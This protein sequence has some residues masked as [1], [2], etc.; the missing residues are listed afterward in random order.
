M[1]QKTDVLS[2]AVVT[3]TT[4]ATGERKAPVK[5][6][7]LLLLRTPCCCCCQ[8][9]ARSSLFSPNNSCT[10][11]RRLVRH[12]DTNGATA[13]KANLHNNAALLSHTLCVVWVVGLWIQCVIR[14]FDKL[15]LNW[16]Y[17]FRHEP[18]EHWK[19]EVLADEWVPVFPAFNRPLVLWKKV[20]CLL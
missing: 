11:A 20:F 16:W 4:A 6:L 18:R 3:T 7:L 19:G 2:W 5:L 15:K 9:I 1:P 17:D 13:R 8:A 14:D 10:A 12:N